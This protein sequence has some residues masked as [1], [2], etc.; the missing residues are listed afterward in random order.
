MLPSLPCRFSPIC[1]FHVLAAQR[2]GRGGLTDGQSAAYRAGRPIGAGG[3]A[4][5]HSGQY[6]SKDT[7]PCTRWY[8]IP[9][10]DSSPLNSPTAK[11]IPNLRQEQASLSASLIARLLLKKSGPT[12]ALQ[13]P[14]PTRTSP[15]A[16]IT[17]TH[18]AYLPLSWAG[19]EYSITAR[20]TGGSSASLQPTRGASQNSLAV[21]AAAASAAATLA[22]AAASAAAGTAAAAASASVPAAFRLPRF[23]GA[24]SGAFPSAAL[25]AAL[26][27]SSVP[28]P[29]WYRRRMA[30][31]PCASGCRLSRLPYR[32]TSTGMSCTSIL[33][34]RPGARGRPAAAA[35]PAT[36]LPATPAASWPLLPAGGLCQLSAATAPPRS[37]STASSTARRP[38]CSS[39]GNSGASLA[40][41]SKAYSGAAGEGCRGQRGAGGEVDS[42]GGGRRELQAQI[43]CSNAAHLALQPSR[44]WCWPPGTPRAGACCRRQRRQ[45]RRQRQRGPAAALQRMSAPWHAC[46]IDALPPGWFSAPRTVHTST[47]DLG[48]LRESKWARAGAATTQWEAFRS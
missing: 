19:M 29:C 44:L 38:G 43:A 11:P 16:H 2:G 26:L 6:A 13:G 5:R 40:A 7:P 30:M 33:S 20:I 45:R 24:A 31:R 47:G 1:P 46:E 12:G 35:L 37:G 17:Q 28:L 21:A 22:A 36:S 48:A 25:L 10:A 32:H 15:H 41:C 23:L 8:G 3:G 9:A 39:S 4:G 18:H 34:C 14:S 27:L 42:T